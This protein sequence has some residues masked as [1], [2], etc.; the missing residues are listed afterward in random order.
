M[1]LGIFGCLA[2]S[3][4]AMLFTGCETDE[5]AAVDSY[6]SPYYTSTSVSTEP[7]FVERRTVMVDNV[8]RD[9]PIY[10]TGDD[11]FYSWGGR[12]FTLADYP[13]MRRTT[14]TTVIRSR[15]AAARYRSVDETIVRRDDLG[16][17]EVIDD[18]V[19]IQETDMGK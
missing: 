14:S 15:P 11:Y 9:V 12:R 10:R 16:D 19:R 13:A 5:V 17:Q 4:A 7:V 8:A 2:G 3:A 1:K 6:R 18:R